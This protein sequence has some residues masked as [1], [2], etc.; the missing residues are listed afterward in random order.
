MSAHVLTCWTAPG[1][2]FTSPTDLAAHQKTEWHRYN[3]MRKVAG[4]TPMELPAFERLR[5]S[6]MGTARA[7]PPP[8]QKD[9]VGKKKKKLTKRQKKKEAAKAR[10]LAGEERISS[11]AGDSADAESDDGGAAAAKLG[12]SEEA[13][14]SETSSYADFG[15]KEDG[16]PDVRYS[17]F[18]SHASESLEENV[19]Y[20]L[21]EHSFFIPDS[22]Y[23]IDLPGLVAYCAEKVRVGNM[24]LFCDRIFPS[25]RACQQHM[26]DS[27]HCQLAYATEEE[28][29][30]YG[31]FYD[32]SE[33]WASPAVLGADGEV[34][35]DALVERAARTQ[36]IEVL[37][38]GELMVTRTDGSSSRI[39]RREMLRYYKQRHRL[40]ESRAD[41]LAN[42]RERMLCL[43]KK[44]GVTQ[45]VAA[46]LIKTGQGRALAARVGFG[47]G[48][49][50]RQ[51]RQQ[52]WRNRNMAIRSLDIGMK[53]NLLQKHA[54]AGKNPIG[55]EGSGIHG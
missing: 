48:A 2:E 40:D 22:K 44:A 30:E 39:G 10:F 23:L 49:V 1:C 34:V 15:L 21:K 18:D 12:G 54:V 24:C 36:R 50:S 28:Q 41:V 55:C 9:H 25:G 37:H 38:N 17:L 26:R 14:S 35:A 6:L 16:E 32:F 46:H 52:V 8:K 19:A 42:Q 29:G 53:H 5:A 4:L 11:A 27:G 45:K 20:M 51:R 47:A 13:D 33:T 3:L 43:Y 31:D 7:P